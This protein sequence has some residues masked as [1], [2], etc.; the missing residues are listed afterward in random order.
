MTYSFA[1]SLTSH[2]L[3]YCQFGSGQP[4]LLIHG[5]G[6]CSE[7][8]FPM[9]EALKKV[10]RITLVDLPGHGQSSPLAVA[11]NSASLSDYA[12]S[13]EQLCRDLDLDEFI[14]G[15]HSLGALIAIEMA[16]NQK[17][18][19]GGLLALN[20][21]HERSDDALAAVQQ[22][23]STLQDSQE[24]VGVEQTISRWFTD[25]PSPAMCDFAERCRS[26]LRANTIEGYAAA[27]HT[28]ANTRGP[29]DQ[30]LSRINCPALFITGLHDRNSSAA[31]SQSLATRISGAEYKIIAD[32]AHMLPL[33]HA[34]AV[35]AAISAWYAQCFGKQ[36]RFE[37]KSS[38]MRL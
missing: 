27:Y 23:A 37:S 38:E 32:A 36:N 9:V 24:I 15:G 17:T 18:S 5:V 29:D 7:S 28:F 4:L 19:I 12:N 35:S 34:N 22:R 8:W 3:A 1:K 13:I 26:W 33:T 30:S 21:I 6:L 25:S 2:G 14:V 31:M 20:A 11:P 10:F 16:A